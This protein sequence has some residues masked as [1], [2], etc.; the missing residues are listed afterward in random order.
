MGCSAIFGISKTNG[1]ISIHMGSG[2][3]TSG[4]GIKIRII[5]QRKK[6]ADPENLIQIHPQLLDLSGTQMAEQNQGQTHFLFHFIRGK[7]RL[8]GS[9]NTRRGAEK[10][11]FLSESYVLPTQKISL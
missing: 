8:W 4:L 5:L 6:S 2:I 10:I 11:V 9:V 7:N 1:V 3:A